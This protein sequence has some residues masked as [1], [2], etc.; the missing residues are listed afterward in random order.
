VLHLHL[1]GHASPVRRVDLPN[2]GTTEQRPLGMPTRADRATQALVKHVLEPAGEA[3]V[4]PNSDGFRPGRS[5]WDALGAIS[6]QIN[7]QPQWVLEA[8]IAKG[9]DRIDHEALL[10]TLNASPTRS[11]QTTAW[12]QGGL[13][14]KG[15]WCP[16]EAGTPPGGPASP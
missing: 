14:E 13:L 11:R 5:P 7:Q 3:Q 2:P 8:D 6:V 10:G 1:E 12:L 16:T 9:F 15:M 4:E